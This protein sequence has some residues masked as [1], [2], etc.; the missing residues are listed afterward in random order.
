MNSRIMK[1]FSRTLGDA[2]LGAVKRAADAAMQSVIEDGRRAVTDAR[3]AADAI[4]RRPATQ[5]VKYTIRVVK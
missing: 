2:L 1:R 4:A 3:A 5:H